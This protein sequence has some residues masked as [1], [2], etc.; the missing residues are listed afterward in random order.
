MSV[1]SI[2]FSLIVIWVI[3]DI[4][5]LYNIDES[6]FILDGK[7]VDHKE[8]ALQKYVS[9]R[10]ARENKI[11]EDNDARIVR[12]RETEDKRATEELELKRI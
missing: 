7:I 5:Y 1:Q 4:V 2:F 9:D 3:F 12:L 6:K 8:A 10:I 11:V